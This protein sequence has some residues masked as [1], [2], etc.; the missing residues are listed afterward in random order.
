[1]A[2]KEKAQAKKNAKALTTTGAL[3]RDAKDG[4]ELVLS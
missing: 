4:Q 1:M 3:R 2:A